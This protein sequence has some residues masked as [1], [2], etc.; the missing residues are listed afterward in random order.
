[1]LDSA[2]RV[3][4]ARDS[5]K[6]GLQTFREHAFL[7]ANIVPH[8]IVTATLHSRLESAG[9]IPVLLLQSLAMLPIQLAVKASLRRSS[10]SSKDGYLD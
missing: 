9:C 6:H 1:M 5:R 10:G 7:P 8:F 3:L 4:A 2:M